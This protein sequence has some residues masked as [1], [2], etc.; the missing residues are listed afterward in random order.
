MSSPI[1]THA[2]ILN[3][4][5]TDAPERELRAALAALGGDAA[6]LAEAALTLHRSRLEDRRRA[7][8]LSVLSETAADL[9]T[10]RDLDELL[11][12]ICRRA[13]LLLSTDV[14]Y[15]TLSDPE[16]GDTHVR[17]TDGIVSEAFRTMRLPAGV[18]IGG[19]VARTGRPEITADY[20]A[21]DHL[22]HVRDVDRRVEEEGLR[23]IVAVPLQ[24]G[25]ESFGV[26]L[27]ASRVVRRFEPQEV[28]L[29]ASLAAHAAVA[30]AN[31]RL[32][33]DSR[34]AV[35]ELA[36]ARDLAQAHATRVERISVAQ[37]R[38]A[39]VALKHGGLQELVEAAHELI[40]GRVELH[41]PEGDELARAGTDEDGDRI[42]VRLPGGLDDL[43]T[44]GVRVGASNGIELEVADRVAGLAAGILL[45]QRVQSEAEYRHRSRLLEELL[46]G[47]GAEDQEVRRS[48]ARGGIS[49]DEPHIVLV[50]AP[51]PSTERWAWLTAARAAGSAHG[52][53]GTV[54]GRLVV[55]VPGADPEEAA[56]R[57]A[58]I[59]RGAGA[60]RPTIGAAP[61]AAW[62]DGLPTAH[63]DATSSLSVLLALGHV[64]RTAT[65]AQLGI[66]GHMLGEPARA[67]LQRF[68][69]R[70]LGCV[71]EHDAHGRS[72]LL[73]V[74]HMFFEESGH[75][76]NTARR[77]H[78]HINTLY[79][80]LARLDKLL[81]ADW[82]DPDRR[83]ELHLA[84]RLRALDT[85]LR[86]GD[87]GAPPSGDDTTDLA[88]RQV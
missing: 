82:R 68:L 85:R 19:L 28:A 70:A 41:G 31:A 38:L 50:V 32:L 64:G 67:D 2:A 87:P 6:E 83:L 66:F 16:R 34:R 20:A 84:L 77:L 48:L 80:R 13:R 8:G 9:A 43:G 53:V 73:P 5:A 18:G 24:H 47:R 21:D 29:F 79:Q 42:G 65:V 88:T 69:E 46:H 74:L 63:R 81:G 4:L 72:E 35:A 61:V 30:I 45:Q 10:H 44:L 40:G 58:E 56:E 26:L 37:E 7:V 86:T 14:A 11:Q 15:V 55:L 36:E 75:L 76:A 54:T 1:R 12:A 33:D 52:L 57:W 51:A 39:A 3:L 78:V 59:M 17:T 25:G 27:S 71:V 23:A 62:F 49:I 22:A 60:E